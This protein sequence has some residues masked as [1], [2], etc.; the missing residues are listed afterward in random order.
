MHYVVFSLERI[1]EVL[2]NCCTLRKTGSKYTAS[3]HRLRQ[4]LYITL[5]QF[6]FLNE[7][8]VMCSN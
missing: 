7:R 1:K 5:L 6:I 3:I 2:L 4:D 8:L